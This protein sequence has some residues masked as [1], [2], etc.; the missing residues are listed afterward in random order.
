MR[1]IDFGDFHLLIGKPQQALPYPG[2]W[3]LSGNSLALAT[4]YAFT[5]LLVD[6]AAGSRHLAIVKKKKNIYLALIYF[7]LHCKH[8]AGHLVSLYWVRIGYPGD[9][10]VRGAA[11]IFETSNRKPRS[12]RIFNSIFFMWLM[13]CWVQSGCA[14]NL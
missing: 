6:I 10:V 3:A 8:L 4:S 1:S 5:L 2:L 13:G 11:G 7:L 9:T 14:Q 12:S